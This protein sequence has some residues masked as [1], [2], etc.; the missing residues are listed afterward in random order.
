MRVFLDLN[1]VLDVLLAR[2]GLAAESENVLLRCDDLNAEMFLAWHSLATAYYLLRRGRTEQDALADI[3]QI[4]SWA[5]IASVTDADARRARSLRFL[6]FEDALQV[7]SAESCVA[8][9]IVTRNLN[10]FRQSKV[11][12]LLPVD[13]LTRYPFPGL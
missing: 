12:A 9:C 5:T 1:V 11:A 7:V 8:N 10:D 2:P 6:D 13:F 4:L 3:D